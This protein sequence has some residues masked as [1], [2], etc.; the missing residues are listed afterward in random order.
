MKFLALI[1]NVGNV[2]LRP[3]GYVRIFVNG[4][5]VEQTSLQWGWPIYPN[6]EHKY[7]GKTEKVDWLPGHYQAELKIECGQVYQKKQ[8]TT[9]KFEF[10]I[11]KGREIKITYEKD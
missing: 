4:K 5:Q 7:L 11:S 10:H 1:R 6:C 3:K 2:H 8:V 9:E